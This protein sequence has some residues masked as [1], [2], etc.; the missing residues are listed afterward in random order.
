[1]IV[2]PSEWA[3]I[4]VVEKDAKR[5]SGVDLTAE[6]PELRS[7]E[8]VEAGLFLAMRCAG[9]SDGRIAAEIRAC[10]VRDGN[11]KWSTKRKIDVAS[12]ERFS[13]VPE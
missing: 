6:P 7:V 12:G 13:F 9:A 4:S 8:V 11:V 10:S 2:G 1:V 5:L 3:S